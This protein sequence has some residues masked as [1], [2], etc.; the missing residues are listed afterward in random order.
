MEITPAIAKLRAGLQSLLHMEPVLR[1]SRSAIIYCIGLAIAGVALLA[2]A[3]GPHALM[4][5]ADEPR[6]WVWI[7]ALV[8]SQRLVVKLAGSVVVSFEELYLLPI[9]LVLPLAHAGLAI[10]VASTVLVLFGGRWGWTNAAFSLAVL[11]PTLLISHAFISITDASPEQVWLL[12]PAV[13]ASLVLIDTAVFGF[14]LMFSQPGQ[15]RSF[16][17]DIA[18]SQLLQWAVV[19]PCAMLATLAAVVNEVGTLAA[20][21]V[22]LVMLRIVGNRMVNASR[23]EAASQARS[24]AIRVAAHELKAPLAAISGFVMTLR[25]MNPEPEQREEWLGIIA[26]QSDRL[27]A[28]ID[29]L[30]IYSRLADGEGEHLELRPVDVL[31]LAQRACSVF[32]DPRIKVQVPAGLQ[33]VADEAALERAVVNLLSNAVK[34]APTGEILLRAHQ[35]EASHVHIEVW[36]EGPGVDEDFAPK[37]FGEF[38][39]SDSALGSSVAGTGLGLAIVRASMRA[40][41]GEVSYRPRL[42]QSVTGSIFTLEL[43]GP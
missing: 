32:E 4:G 43:A 40:M 26:A 37:L 12:V 41:D 10:L 21:S 20:L 34:Y 11:P 7:A 27:H 18:H 28:I 36:D 29:D 13:L 25:Q 16:L 2:I 31:P 1:P 14:F 8:L 24:Q 5:A 30:L 9:V 22:P 15:V 42:S 35:V 33:V 23:L 3:I 38:S 17:R 39:R 6:L 19:L